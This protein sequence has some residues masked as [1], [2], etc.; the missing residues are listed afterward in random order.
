[1]RVGEAAEDSPRDPLLTA[2]KFLPLIKMSLK[3][4]PAIAE[5]G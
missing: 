2:F 4:K 5:R 3:F 1:M